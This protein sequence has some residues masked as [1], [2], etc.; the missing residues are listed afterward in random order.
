MQC[1]LP[2]TNRQCDAC[3]NGQRAPRP[4]SWARRRP[5]PNGLVI[6]RAFYSTG[7]PRGA[8]AVASRF[9]PG[10]K[11]IF[12]QRGGTYCDSL[13][14]SFYSLAPEFQVEWRSPVP[15]S[16]PFKLV[17]GRQSGGRGST[18]EEGRSS[19]WLETLFISAWRLPFC[20]SLVR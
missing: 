11:A 5:L 1:R 12:R 4:T 9:P 19:G 20:S 10:K 15:I 14:D 7:K 6:S 3:P 13:T 18:E 17:K 16:C 8:S 2:V